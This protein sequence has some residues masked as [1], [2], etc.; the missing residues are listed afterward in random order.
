MPTASNN[1]FRRRQRQRIEKL[2]DEGLSTRVIHERLGVTQRQVLRIKK[3]LQDSREG[4]I[5][6][7]SGG[8]APS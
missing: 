1:D 8:A 7:Q 2:L 6:D 4:L 5:N 3:Q